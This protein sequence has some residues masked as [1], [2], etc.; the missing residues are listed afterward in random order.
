MPK[1]EVQTVHPATIAT[2]AAPPT[3]ASG[4][5]PASDPPAAARR[6]LKSGL[7]AFGIIRADEFH[8]GRI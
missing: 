3:A 8:A 1:S 7:L 6:G 5:P 2:G 4:L